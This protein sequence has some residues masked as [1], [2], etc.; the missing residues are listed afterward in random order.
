MIHFSIVKSKCDL[1]YR[2]NIHIGIFLIKNVFP[3][4]NQSYCEQHFFT[5]T[6]I[7]LNTI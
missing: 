2:K 4:L 1:M 5:I 7:T 6:F 3:D